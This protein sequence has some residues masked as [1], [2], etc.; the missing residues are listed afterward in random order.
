MVRKVPR[1]K[2]ATQG[3]IIVAFRAKD[4]RT[5]FRFNLRLR[6]GGELEK[7]LFFYEE[8]RKRFIKATRA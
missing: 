1:V 4:S 2:R 7:Q 8:A 6:P 3:Q 5:V